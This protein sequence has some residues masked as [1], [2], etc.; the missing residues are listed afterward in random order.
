MF[1]NNVFGIQNIALC[2]ILFTIIIY[3]IMTPLTYKQQ[4][5][6]RLT[7][8]MQ[9]EI[10]AIREK[11]KNKK[12]QASMQKMNEETQM[13]YEKYGVSTMGSCVQLLINFPIFIAMYQVVRNVPAYVSSVKDVFIPLVDKI[14]NVD[15][16]QKVMENV[17]KESGTAGIKIGRAH[18]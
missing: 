5:F 4:K 8:E 17:V 6:S 7:Q 16:F 11:Y 10:N 1:L 14:V 18:V 15:G 13:V 2:I 9:P 12:D 3:L